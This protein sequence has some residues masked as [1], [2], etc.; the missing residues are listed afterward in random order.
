MATPR[1]RKRK[2]CSTAP[3][4]AASCRILFPNVSQQEMST[5]F[6]SKR[7]APLIS[8]V[9]SV[10]KSAVRP[11]SSRASMSAPKPSKSAAISTWSF[12]IAWWRGMLSAGKVSGYER[13][14]SASKSKLT[15]SL[16]PSREAMVIAEQPF[17][18]E[19][20]SA[21]NFRSRFTTLALPASAAS[22]SASSSVF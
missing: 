1:S 20:A 10:S 5:P 11:E 21:P 6:L 14:A 4:V 12:L 3:L 8:G 17:L 19:S 13:L 22:Q 9:L 15:T 16:C 2:A 7:A 18:L